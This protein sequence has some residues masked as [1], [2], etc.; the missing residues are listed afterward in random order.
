MQ[1][2]PG[3]VGWRTLHAAPALYACTLEEHG[4]GWSPTT[5][6]VMRLCFCAQLVMFAVDV[7]QTTRDNTIT[8]KYQ[9]VKAGFIRYSDA[10]LLVA[11]GRI[12]QAM[13]NSSVFTD[14]HPPL[15]DIEAAFEDYRQ[16]VYAAGG[17][18]LIYNTARRESKRRLAGLLQKLALYVNIMADGNLST[19]H[20]SGFPVMGRRKK[21]QSPDTPGQPFLR[22]GRG[23]LA[24]GRLRTKKRE[25]TTLL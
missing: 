21:G 17:G 8:M 16:K 6:T 9:R 10:E 11:A 24:N 14:P 3:V 15:T 22:D 23:T 1:F 12:L 2:H 20:G 13:K 5:G 25:Q 19:L 7:Y 18:G 4:C